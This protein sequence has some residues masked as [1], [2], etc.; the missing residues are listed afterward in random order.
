[1]VAESE[2]DP[3]TSTSR[4]YFEKHGKAPSILPVVRADRDLGRAFAQQFHRHELRPQKP[5]LLRIPG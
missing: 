5:P 4:A 1:M 3:L 2:K